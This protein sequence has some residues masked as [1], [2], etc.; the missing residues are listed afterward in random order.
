M[1]RLDHTMIFVF[2]AGT[3]T[4]ALLV[5]HGTLAERGADRRL[6]YRRRAESFSTWSGSA[7]PTGSALW[8]TWA[9]AGLRS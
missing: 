4:F 9:P 6:G 2:I 3:Y 7:P 1:R 5:M 8:S